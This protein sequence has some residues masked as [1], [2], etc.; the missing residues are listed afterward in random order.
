M[1]KC[2][3]QRLLIK[4][5]YNTIQGFSDSVKGWGGMGSFVAGE[6]FIG[7]GNLRRSVLDHLNLF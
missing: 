4:Q 5:H 3:W 1:A 2:E 6:G 7:I